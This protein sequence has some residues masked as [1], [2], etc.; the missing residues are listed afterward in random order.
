MRR[1]E[2]AATVGD[3]EQREALAGDGLDGAVAGFFRQASHPQLHAVRSAPPR[4]RKSIVALWF[5]QNAGTGSHPLRV[6]FGDDPAAA[7]E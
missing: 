6:A 7:V 2:R 1:T 4:A 3:V 5:V